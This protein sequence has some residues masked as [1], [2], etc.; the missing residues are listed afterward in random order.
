MTQLTDVKEA[1]AGAGG[2]SR[3]RVGPRALALGAL[4]VFGLAGALAA[5]PLPRLRQQRQPDAAPAGA[6]DQPPRVTVAVAQRLAPTAERVLPGNA[7]PLMEAGLFARAT[8]YV[9][10]RLVDIGDR[11]RQ[12]QLLA[13]ISAPDTDDQ[14]AEAR[15]NLQLAQA[16]LKLNE[17]NAVLAR[18]VLE[19][20][21]RIRA[22]N[23]SAISQE[24]LDQERATAV[25][26]EA[27]VES[28][29]ANI[30]VN[31]AK[32][33]RFA[34]LQ[35]FERITAPFAGVITARN[36]ETGDL[37]TADSTSRE[38]FHLMRTDTLRVLVK[39]PQ[40][41]VASVA[42]GQEAAVFRRHDTQTQHP[43]KVTRT[44]HALDPDTRTL[45]T[46][47]DVPNPE[48]ALRPGMDLQVRFAFDRK[49]SPLTIPA[50]ALTRRAGGPR[51]AVMDGQHRVRY[52]T[53]ELGRDS[54]AE[55]EVLAGLSPGEAVVVP[56]GDDLPEGAAVEPVALP[57]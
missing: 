57:K 53:V 38:L 13:E 52:R 37:V 39:V 20:S 14:L 23:P 8:G 55:V 49:V 22:T 16:S 40:A 43:G 6:A 4:I 2:E 11:V 5:D 31:E 47:V 33:R 51:V 10:R 45:L 18:R 25:T 9:S 36:V 35:R 3:R 44:A 24:E 1:P 48:D 29:R 42:A 46:Q 34:D 50:A 19:R 30:L 12:G 15:A 28:A 41:S 7:L 27:S 17:A 21:Q 54:G 32:V 56:P 26:A